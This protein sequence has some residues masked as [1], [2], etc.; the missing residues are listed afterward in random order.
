MK[1]SLIVTSRGGVKGVEDLKRLFTSLSMQ[2]DINLKNL[3]IIFVDQSSVYEEIKSLVVFFNFKYLKINP[4]SLSSARNQAMHLVTGVLL[5]FPDDD[6][7]FHSNFFR[8]LVNYF[9]DNIETS[10]LICNIIDPTNNKYYGNKPLVK[11]NI[12]D[13]D[14]YFLP[15]SVSMF[16]NINIVE[17]FDIYFDEDLGIGAKWGAGEDVELS[18]RIYTKYNT[19]FYNGYMNVFHPVV[20]GG[21]TPRKAYEYGAGTGAL[22]ANL[23][24]QSHYK[25]IKVFL[26]YV[27]RSLLGATFYL[28]LFRK[29]NFLSYFNRMVG[30]ITGFIRG[31]FFFS[32]K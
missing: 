4:S 13:Y 23:I 16:I 27:I 22:A 14:I 12:D 24:I 17:N 7:W 25:H 31:L 18:F 21:E 6:C 15:S 32:N 2:K 8:E 30:L 5:G 29:N 28:L 9:E 10:L 1:I 26:R 20:E 19:C 11:K 3:E